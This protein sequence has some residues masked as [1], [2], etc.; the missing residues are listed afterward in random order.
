LK[1]LESPKDSL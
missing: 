1:A